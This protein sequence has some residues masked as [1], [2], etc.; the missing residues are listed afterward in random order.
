V[1][2]AAR[3]YLQ[4]VNVARP[5]MLALVTANLVNLAGN[6]ALV[7]GHWGAPALGVAGSAWATVISRVYMAL[8]LLCVIF[9]REGVAGLRDEARPNI[10]R[11]RRLLALG[12]PAG[13]QILLEVG[14]FAAAAAL[15]GRLDAASLAGHQIA[16]NSV[17]TTFMVTLGIG[18]AAAVRVGQAL[19]RKDRS[20]AA[21][22]GWTA[23]ALGTA[24]MTCAATLFL[25]LPRPFARIYTSD[26]NVIRTAIALLGV[27]AFFQIFD[28]LQVVVSG[29]LRGLGDTRTPMIC[30]LLGYWGVGLPLGYVLCF[31][32]GWGAFGMWIGLCAG[33]IL[34]GTVLLG[35]WARRVRGW[36][37]AAEVTGLGTN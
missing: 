36:L 28:G 15:I 31:Q 10:A 11:M 37:L 8:L 6:W 34:I 24:F 9:W 25:T 33:L 14:V 26:E 20:A 18:S 12:F 27:G 17:A 21:R 19:G 2:F 32:A 1:Y 16:L 29:A 23:L 5:V 22:S 35:L 7:Y 4:S 3:R 30:H 13:T